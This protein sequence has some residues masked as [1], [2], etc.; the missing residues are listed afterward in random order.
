MD[1][2]SSTRTRSFSEGKQGTSLLVPKDARR[3]QLT[4]THLAKPFEIVIEE[5]KST[6][7]SFCYTEDKDEDNDDAGNWS[8]EVETN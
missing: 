4:E 5:K 6:C 1:K 3:K 7:S 2:G 8:K